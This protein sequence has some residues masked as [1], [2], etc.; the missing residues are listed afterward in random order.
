MFELSKVDHFRDRLE[1]LRFRYKMQWHLFE[2]GISALDKR[3]YLMIIEGE[4]GI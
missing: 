3:G 1:F 4:R 2:I